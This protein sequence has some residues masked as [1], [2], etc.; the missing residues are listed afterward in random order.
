MR[1]LWEWRGL[2]VAVAALAWGLAVFQPHD[3]LDADRSA[4]NSHGEDVLVV[5]F[6]LACGLA[7]LLARAWPAGLPRRAFAGGLLLWVGAWAAVGVLRD[8]A[9]APSGIDWHDSLLGA[10]ALAYDDPPLYCAARYPLYPAL[11]AALHPLGLSLDLALQLVSRL[12]MLLLGLPLAWVARRWFGEV[13]ALATLGLL[14]C[15]PTFH[16]HLDAVTPYPTVM[17]AAATAVAS[18]VA[19]VGGGLGAFALAG[20][21]LGAL[22]AAEAKA[23]LVAGLLLPLGMIFALAA[24]A[25]AGLRA[26]G[27]RGLRLL[28][29]LGPIAGSYAWAGSLPVRAETLESLASP[30]LFPPTDRKSVV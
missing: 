5:G 22:L 2:V 18:L 20:L 12:E 10:Y 11:G 24:P 29:L 19:A 23:L 16:H 25:G 3:L 1:R 13:A 4:A 15:V 6:V 26:W 27:R 9:W 7:G 8:P 21:A 14:V 17:L 30:T 28:L